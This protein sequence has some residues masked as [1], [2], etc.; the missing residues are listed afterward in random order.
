MAD[1]KHVVKFQFSGF[2]PSFTISSGSSSSERSYGSQ[3]ISPDIPDEL[4]EKPQEK[5]PQLNQNTLIKPKKVGIFN[6]GFD[7][8]C[9]NL[10]F[11]LLFLDFNELTT[12]IFISSKY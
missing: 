10:N 11:C 4:P 3:A 5:P 12:K 8:S 9:E 1:P 7:N 6:L 2:S